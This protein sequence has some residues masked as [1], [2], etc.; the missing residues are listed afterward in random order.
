MR[1]RYSAGTDAGSGPPPLRRPGGG[2]TSSAKIEH[3]V[4]GVE[5]PGVER[6]RYTTSNGNS[7]CSSSHRIHP[8][9]IDPPYSSTRTDARRRHRHRVARRPGATVVDRDPE[10]TGPRP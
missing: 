1:S 5:V 3:V 7:Y 10:C 6:R 8:D 2:T 9:G 4:P